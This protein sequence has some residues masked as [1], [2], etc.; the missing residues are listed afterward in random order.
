MEVLILQRFL[1]NPVEW[2][3]LIAPYEVHFDF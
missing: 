2:A 1:V 3:L